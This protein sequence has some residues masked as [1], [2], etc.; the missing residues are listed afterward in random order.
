MI[1]PS[2]ALAVV[3][4]ATMGAGAGQGTESGDSST[5]HPAFTQQYLETACYAPDKRVRQ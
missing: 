3:A 4:S 1:R 2:G 5:M